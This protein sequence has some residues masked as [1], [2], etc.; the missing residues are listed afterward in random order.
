MTDLLLEL[1]RNYRQQMA[2][3]NASSPNMTLEE[4]EALRD[5]TWGPPYEQLC[6]APPNATTLEGAVEAIRLVHDEEANCGN[7]P[8]LTINVLAAA[9]AFFD[10]EAQP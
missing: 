2:A 9:L 5:A 10:D 1:V 4:D 7:Q 3:F 8:G 6:T